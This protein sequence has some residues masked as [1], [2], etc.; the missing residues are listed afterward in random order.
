MR[1]PKEEREIS[2]GGY[3]YNP[4]G[5][6]AERM[7]VFTSDYSYMA[8]LDRY[9]EENPEEWKI[10]AVNSIGYDIISKVYSCPTSC[11]SFR[12]KTVKGREMTEE[13]KA[14]RVE[15]MQAARNARSE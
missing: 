10:E 13:E 12:K 8:K 15:I 1:T 4:D 3:T 9:C 6:R 7:Q 14:R 5:T 11:L 2:A